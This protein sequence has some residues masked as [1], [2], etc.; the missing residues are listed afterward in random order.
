MAFGPYFGSSAVAM[1]GEKPP[2]TAADSCAPSDAPL[3][4]T[5]VP[6]NSEKNAPCGAYIGACE[7]RNTSTSASQM[8]GVDPV[9]NSQNNGNASTAVITAPN[10]Y[11]GRR[12]MRS[13]NQP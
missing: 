2:A 12:P 4:R 6:N 13:V 3:Y 10:M 7:Q 11:T 9:S 1:S 8:S 5:L